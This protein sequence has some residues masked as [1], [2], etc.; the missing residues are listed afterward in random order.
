MGKGRRFN[1]GRNWQNY[2]AGIGDEE[3]DRAER[4]LV[5][6]LGK[7]DLNGTRFID[8]GCGSGLFSLAAVRLGASVLSFDCDPDSVTCT[9]ALRERHFLGC[10]RWRI[11]QGSVLDKSYLSELGKFDIVYSWGVLHHTGAM[12]AALENAAWLVAD[13]GILAISL[14][15]KTPFCAA[16]KIEKS[17]Y[18]RAPAGV[19][20]IICGTFK[21]AFFAGLVATG[22]NPFTYVRGYKSNRG[23]A[24]HNDVH[25]WLGGWPYESASTESVSEHLND[26]GF[27]II[28][29]FVSP[30]GIGLF[31]TGCDEFVASRTSA[32]LST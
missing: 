20:S 12:W 19:Q 30:P 9:V 31:G 4:S 27:K 26:C 8:V 1:F 7:K 32:A 23:M 22:R 21:A 2:A 16:W 6:L 18:A 17:L 13:D 3:I 28:R 15:R 11:A 25:D 24:W 10:N 29:S 5:R 14:Y